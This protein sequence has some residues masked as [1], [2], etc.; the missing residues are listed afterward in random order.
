MAD[1]VKGF[2]SAGRKVC[3]VFGMEKLF[4]K[5]L[6]LVLMSFLTC[7][8]DS[9]SPLSSRWLLYFKPNY[10]EAMMDLQRIQ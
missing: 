1:D 6:L 9:E 4:S 7:Q 3:Q 8:R 10:H 2:E 5:R